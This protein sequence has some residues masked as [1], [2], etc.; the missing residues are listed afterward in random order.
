M[1]RQALMATLDPPVPLVLL[2]K[3][4]PKVLEEIQVPLAELVTLDF[5]ALQDLLA[6]KENLEMMVPLVPM[7]LQVP[8][9]WLVKEA[10][11][12]CLDSVVREDSLA[13]LAHRVS[14]ASRVHLVH[15]ETEVLL[16]PW[17]LLA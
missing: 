6:R 11:L 3:M 13:F 12:V 2:E 16:A 10:L 14:L 4:A 5:K 17:G 8:R 9:G 1:D 15:L 7:V